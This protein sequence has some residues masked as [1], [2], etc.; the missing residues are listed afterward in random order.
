MLF[1]STVG[2]G[3]AIQ[4]A[5]QAQRALC[6]STHEPRFTS[7][8][9]VRSASPT[10][11]AQIAVGADVQFLFTH[12]WSFPQ[13]AWVKV[14]GQHSNVCL[15]LLDCDT[16]AWLS[17]RLSP[18]SDSEVYDRPDIAQMAQQTLPSDGFPAIALAT[19]LQ[20]MHNY[21]LHGLEPLI[22]CASAPECLPK[23][24]SSTTS[25]LDPNQRPAAD[26]NDLRLQP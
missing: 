26:H 20:L 6:G 10:R 9:A 14:V 2:G 15:E 17:M 18:S 13:D 19:S 5:I 23:S 1:I 8:L 3:W 22:L 7:G 25:L 24:Q 4:L 21:L 12:F 11:V 16:F